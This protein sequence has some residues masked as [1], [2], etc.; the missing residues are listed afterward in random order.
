MAMGQALYGWTMLTVQEV[1]QKYKTVH[2]VDGVHTI[3]IDLGM[4]SAYQYWFVG[5]PTQ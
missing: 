4:Q 3:V 2:T 1:R 5:V